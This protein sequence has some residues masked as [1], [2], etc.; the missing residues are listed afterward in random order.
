MMCSHFCLS[1]LLFASLFHF[2]LFLCHS[3]YFFIFEV[4][5]FFSL[6]LSPI[7]LPNIN[8]H[9]KCSE[10]YVDI[11]FYNCYFYQHHMYILCVWRWHKYYTHTCTLMYAVDIQN[12]YHLK[13]KVRKKVSTRSDIRIFTHQFTKILAIISEQ[14]RERINEMLN[15]SIKVM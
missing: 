2:L 6:S 9:T 12:I 4:C 10:Y 7:W 13:K 11:L 14:M 3:S 15:E 5:I 1:A 8:R